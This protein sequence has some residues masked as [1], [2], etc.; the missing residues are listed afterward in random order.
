MLHVHLSNRVEHLAERLVEV[1]RPPLDNPFANDC[2][3]VQSLGM[4]RWLEMTLAT[5]TGVWAN[6]WFPFPEAL[7]RKLRRDVLDESAAEHAFDRTGLAFAVA[8]AIA[9]DRDAPAYAPLRH[10]LGAETGPGEPSGASSTRLIALAER[11]ADVFDGYQ[12]HRPDVLLAWEADH[13]GG[14][15]PADRVHRGI[16]R[17]MNVGHE[18]DVDTGIDDPDDAW[19]PYLWRAVTAA[20]PD[21]SRGAR[22]TE[23]LIA[24]LEAGRKPSDPDFA[25]VS[26]FGLSALSPLYIRLLSAL[27]RHVE[28]NVFALAASTIGAKSLRAHR[29]V[30]GMPGG[31][32]PEARA[33]ADVPAAG[34]PLLRSLG[35][36]AR[37]FQI[38][39][40]SVAH[41]VTFDDL[42]AN[43]GSVDTPDHPVAHL[44]ALHALQADIDA[45][46][47]R[48]RPS[49]VARLIAGQDTSVSVHACHGPLREVEVLRDQLIAAFAADETLAPHDIAVLTPDIAGYAPYIDAV[50][51]AVRLDGCR[52]PFAIAD[53]P[54]RESL[55]VV[56]AFGQ[57]LHVLR[58]RFTAAEVLD[59]LALPPVRKRFGLP[60]ADLEAVRDW[61]AASG[62]RW[63]ADADHRRSVG[64][65]AEDANT[66]RFGLDRLLLG[67]AVGDEGDV[68]GIEVRPGDD[69]GGGGDDEARPGDDAGDGAGGGMFERTADGCFRSVLP[70]LD[71]LAAPPTLGALCAFADHL[72]AARAS[73]VAPRPA[74][75]WATALTA[76]LAETIAHDG[77]TAAQHG[78]L[79]AALDDLADRA[80]AAGFV[81]DLTLDSVSDH[82]LQA[83]DAD[84]GARGFLSGGLTFCALAPM[85]SIPFRVVAL[86]GMNDGAFPRPGRPFAFDLVHRR[87]RVGDR[88]ARDD[89]RFLFL[90]ALL[91][92]RDRFIVTFNGQSMNDNSRFPPSV[93]VS[94]L[95]DALVAF[96]PAS[97]TT[98]DASAIADALVTWHPLQPFSPRYFTASAPSGAAEAPTDDP[99]D[100]RLFSYATAYV[101]AAACLVGART[102][103][104]PF[105]TSAVALGRRA[106][107][108]SEADEPD[109]ALDD[110]VAFFR[111]PARHLLRHHLGI[112]FPGD[113]TPLE[114]REPLALDG[115]GRYAVGDAVLRDLLAGR[116]AATAGARVRAAGIAP[117]GTPGAVALAPIVAQAAAIA[118]AAAPWLSPSHLP[119]IEFALQL[120]PIDAALLPNTVPNALPNVAGARSGAR[121]VGTLAGVRPGG[122]VRCSFARVDIA[123]TLDLWIEHVVLCALRSLG[124][125][126]THSAHAAPPS[127]PPPATHSRR[128]G[129]PPAADRNGGAA[130]I[131]FGPVE[132]PERVLATLVGLYRAG[133]RGWLPFLPRA[134]H[135]FAAAAPDDV[136]VHASRAFR[137]ARRAFDP[138]AFAGGGRG[139]GE[140]EWVHLVVGDAEPFGEDGDP[141][142]QTAFAEIACAVYRPILAAIIADGAAE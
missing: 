56:Q 88:R 15:S 27:A 33:M 40:G 12:L 101:P 127:A 62:I 99:S 113:E 124:V 41:E 85:R 130:T 73:C 94:E 78:R 69:A 28:V 125:P 93:V 76:L 96:D 10:Y 6:G 77:A 80:E 117:I 82:V 34:H 84:D 72:A 92:A 36:V 9:A 108:G 81:G 58:G 129:R 139:E 65:P 123:R 118:A 54:G 26:V 111:H 31:R 19:Q 136:P 13:N 67:V 20:H 83:V 134:S 141:D 135:A 106:I 70:A 87:P 25:R 5:A 91:A 121:L 43:E 109:I 49:V 86:L 137:E 60:A 14:V 97:A 16:D 105:V 59:L 133:L 46:V 115:L 55:A 74:R 132:A 29:A 37:E 138:P 114:E 79:R 57:L 126:S 35:T 140:D 100:G 104:T 11:I 1:V 116:S 24:A 53:R 63:A 122:L 52:L 142:W 47:P 120:P 66:W 32:A 8:A 30:G 39:A 45:D 119:P 42:P 4:Q 48:T 23:R 102:H 95:L 71:A 68:R 22:Q 50:F 75:A 103:A 17:G 51:G 18:V 110:L 98:A 44:G 61:V 38:L 21:R 107:A 90:E 128:I 131:V 89:D 2:I 112:A 64:Q 3:V 7:A